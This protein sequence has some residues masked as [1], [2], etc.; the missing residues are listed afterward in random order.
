MADFPIVDLQANS[1]HNRIGSNEQVDHLATAIVK[2][3]SQ[4]DHKLI[5]PTRSKM[6]ELTTRNPILPNLIRQSQ[7][8]SDRRTNGS[9]D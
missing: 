6:V 4:R 7:I 8:R 1:T 9:I 5:L 2:S 3:R